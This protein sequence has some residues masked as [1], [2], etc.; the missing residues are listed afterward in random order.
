MIRTRA[1]ALVALVAVLALPLSAA[2]PPAPALAGAV[3]AVAPTPTA[4]ATGAV[5]LAQ[6]LGLPPS[7][8][9]PQAPIFLI[10]CPIIGITCCKIEIRN[11]C[12][13]CTDYVTCH[14]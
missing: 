3:P 9:S 7:V 12:R 2:T 6:A 1:L 10:P 8:G 13:I 14:L 5:P 11:G 4:P